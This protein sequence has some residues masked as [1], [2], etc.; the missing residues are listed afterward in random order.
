MLVYGPKHFI[1]LKYFTVQ[2]V[3]AEIAV[4][5]ATD[6]CNNIENDDSSNASS[7]N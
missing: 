3:L 5:L 6:H 4:C 1:V 2:G 7:C